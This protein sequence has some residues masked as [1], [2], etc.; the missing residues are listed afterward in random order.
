M[1]LSDLKAL[2]AVAR[3]DAQHRAL[4]RVQK[5]A[6]QRPTRAQ[7]SLEYAPLMGLLDW[8]VL[9]VFVA[10]L[11]ISSLNIIAHMGRLAEAHYAPPAAGIHIPHEAATVV[12]QLASIPLAEFS[13]IAFLVAFG[14]T[15]GWRD[16]R[17]PSFSLPT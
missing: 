4:R 16:W 1:N 8:L 10:A 5:L 12:F 2:S 6:G 13:M 15:Q 14:M 17:R 3:D 11:V 7:F 9:F